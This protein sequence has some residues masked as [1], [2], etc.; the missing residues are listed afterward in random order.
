VSPPTR[1]TAGVREPDGPPVPRGGV[2]SLLP[3]RWIVPALAVVVVL[4]LLI[5]V[6]G[7]YVYNAPAVDQLAPG[8]RVDAVIAFGGRIESADY[9]RRLVEQGAAPVLVLSD[10]YRP[11]YAPSVEAACGNRPAVG[12][13]VLCFRPDPSTTRGEAQEIGRLARA[14]GWTDVAVVAPVFHVSRGRVLV[15]RCYSGNLSFL[16]APMDVAW[17]NW[18]YQYARQSAGFVKVAIQREC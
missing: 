12:Y 13:R 2:V 14:N 8:R 6:G 4:G 9:A 17:Y 16:A 7:H 3:R 5:G 15:Q 11:G 18:T 1:H 10:P